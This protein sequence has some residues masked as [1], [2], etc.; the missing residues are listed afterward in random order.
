MGM[1]TTI[2]LLLLQVMPPFEEEE[3]VKVSAEPLSIHG[4]GMTELNIIVERVNPEIAFHPKESPPTVEVKSAPD[5][6]SLVTERLRIEEEESGFTIVVPVV[7][8]EIEE[9]TETEIVLDVEVFYCKG[10]EWCRRESF[11]CRVKLRLLKGSASVLPYVLYIFVVV[12]AVSVLVSAL[13]KVKT[14]LLLFL[15]VEAV[16]LL[17]VA[18]ATG[19][20][21]TA[22]KIA[23]EL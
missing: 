5:N 15:S 1:L 7:A 17:I 14:L 22:R 6:I 3:Y 20:H 2:L 13:M 21:T 23:E 11:P 4:G 18:F 12:G 10:E 8:G 19:Q 9:E 16:F